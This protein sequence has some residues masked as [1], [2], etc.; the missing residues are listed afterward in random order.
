MKVKLTG[1]MVHG[2][3]LTPLGRMVGYS[4]TLMAAGK[5]VGAK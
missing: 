3:R 5:L 1:P 4:I 2:G